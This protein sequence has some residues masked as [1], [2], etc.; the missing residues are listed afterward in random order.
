MIVSIGCGDGCEGE[1]RD[2]RMGGAALGD[3]LGVLCLCV[4]IVT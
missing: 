3:G 1:I 2:G 4:A